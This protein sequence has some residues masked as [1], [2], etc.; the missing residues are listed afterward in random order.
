MAMH[1]AAPLLAC[2]S[3][4]EP[5]V[6]LWDLDVETFR[7][8]TR[9]DL[10]SRPRQRPR[11]SAVVDP[12]PVVCSAC[13]IAA[14][15]QQRA[16]RLARGYDWMTCPVCDQRV[17]C[18]AVLPPDESLIEGPESAYLGEW[19]EGL[20]S[21][22]G[23]MKSRDFLC[24]AGGNHS[25]LAVAF[26]DMIGSTAL[27]NQLGNEAMDE[28]RA[29][30]FRRGLDVIRELGGYLIKTIG[31]SLMAA[32]RTA[33]AALDFALALHQDPGSPRVRL[34]VGIHV[35]LVRV[36]ESDAFGTMVNY[37]ARVEQQAPGA[38]IW[39]SDRARADVAEER[40]KKH[41]HLQWMEHPEC[42]LKGFPGRHRL[43]SVVYPGMTG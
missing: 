42:E 41:S 1:P 14:T 20:A 7:K 17:S 6:Q 5:D 37:A 29:A 21:A 4:E 2:S 22:A 27:S 11:P 12:T 36:E 30:H 15:G 40:A 26:T 10:T 8:P 31:D 33:V 34:R 9:R 28:V 16:A 35:G 24:W 38:E 3:A 25:T 39:L 19:D 43:W 23:E 32:F 13:G 18:L